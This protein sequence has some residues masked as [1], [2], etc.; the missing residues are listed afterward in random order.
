MNNILAGS[1]CLEMLQHE[2]FG[3]FFFFCLL[4]QCACGR[5][6]DN[7]SL[8]SETPEEHGKQFPWQV[9]PQVHEVCYST[10]CGW[11]YLTIF[12]LFFSQV[13]LLNSEGKGFCGGVLL[14]SNFVLTTAE[15]AL[16]H[17]HFK[18]RVGAGR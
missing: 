4:D 17:N 11:R 6:K 7:N 10:S 8:I 5:L 3:C 18:I 15:C 1:F 9:F 13:L 12:F 14:K 16:L 2:V